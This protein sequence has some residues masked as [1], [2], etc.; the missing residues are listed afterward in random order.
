MSGN[1]S[2]IT[3]SIKVLVKNK[4]PIAGAMSSISGEKTHPDAPEDDV[5]DGGGD[6]A[7]SKYQTV[8]K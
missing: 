7:F 6:K 4:N 3:Q 2:T 1:L 5:R 8:K